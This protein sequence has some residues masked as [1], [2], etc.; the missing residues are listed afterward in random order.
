M[1]LRTA[2]TLLI[3]SVVFYYLIAILN[4]LI[5]YDL[6]YQCIQHVLTMDTI[7]PDNNSMWRALTAPFW[8]KF[9]FVVINIWEIVT[10]IFCCWGGI[11]MVQAIR[12]DAAVFNHAKNIAIAALTLS[13]LMWLVGFLTIGGEWF[14]MWQSKTWNFQSGAL[15]MFTFIGIIMLIVMQP[16]GA[17]TKKGSSLEL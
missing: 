16:D 15:R 7:Y 3:F 4:N 2:K 13:L 10:L 8:H 9:V 1:I 17:V 11:R 14:L 6:N 12:S 5:D